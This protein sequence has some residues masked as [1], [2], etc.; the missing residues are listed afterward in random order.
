MPKIT[1]EVS[2]AVF[3]ALEILGRSRGNKE[4]GAT[5][6]LLALA[7]HAEQGLCRPGS[8]ERAWVTQVFFDD[9]REKL[10]PD[11]HARWRLRPRKR[12]EAG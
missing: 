8:W 7:D 3:E 11:P 4:A 6:A 9:W 10:E 5:Q 2:D 1:I 12:A